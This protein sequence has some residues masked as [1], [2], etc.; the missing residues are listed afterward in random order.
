[1]TKE[2]KLSKQELEIAQAACCVGTM[3]DEYEGTEDFD[4]MVRLRLNHLIEL[5]RIAKTSLLSNLDEAA[6]EYFLQTYGID[7]IA[8]SEDIKR[9]VKFGAEWMTGQGYTKEG[10]ARP[11]DCE[12]WVN[13]TN[14]DIKD[15][16][17]VIIQIRKKQ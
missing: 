8:I 11:D 3:W 15:G 17:E 13:F 10:I 7:N 5:V 6:E 4:H 9:A 16:D 14:T 1:M 12:I 2:P